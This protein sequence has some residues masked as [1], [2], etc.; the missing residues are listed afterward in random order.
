MRD[1]THITTLNLI[2]HLIT[3]TTTPIHTITMVITTP[4]LTG[5]MV[6]GVIMVL[7]VRVTG[8]MVEEDSKVVAGAV[9][10]MA[11][12]AGKLKEKVSEEGPMWAFFFCPIFVSSNPDFHKLL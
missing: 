4:T 10:V 1:M 11:E 5:V 3:P 7:G 2:T 8:V 9:A 6:D 12:A